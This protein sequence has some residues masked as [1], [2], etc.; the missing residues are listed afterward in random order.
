[1]WT[2]SAAQMRAF[3][4]REDRCVVARVTCLLH[5][6]IQLPSLCAHCCSGLLG[7]SCV[8]V[9]FACWYWVI[10]ATIGTALLLVFFPMLALLNTGLCVALIATSPAWSLVLQFLTYLFNAFVADMYRPEFT[11]RDSSVGIVS[12]R[13]CC[14]MRRRGLL[15]PVLHVCVCSSVRIAVQIVRPGSCC[16]VLPLLSALLH[17]LILGVGQIGVSVVGVIGALLWAVLLTVG[18]ATSFRALVSAASLGCNAI[19]HR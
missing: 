4:Q 18:G 13:R 15:L 2:S 8:R 9:L 3:E 5:L 7:K 12:C 11:L 19:V 17:L 10:V 1:L 14:C 16:P 6:P